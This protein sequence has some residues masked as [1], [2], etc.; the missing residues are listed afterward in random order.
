MFY[1]HGI[2]LVTHGYSVAPQVLCSL[3]ITA[4]QCLPECDATAIIFFC[5][6]QGPGKIEEIKF[7]KEEKDQWFKHRL[8]LV[9][10]FTA[11]MLPLLTTTI[12][13]AEIPSARAVTTSPQSPGMRVAEPQMDQTPSLK[14]GKVVYDPKDRHR[15]GTITRLFEDGKATVDWKNE[16]KIRDKKYNGNKLRVAT[17]VKDDYERPN[18]QGQAV[19]IVASTM[20]PHLVGKMGIV[21]RYST[22]SSSVQTEDGVTVKIKT[23]NLKLVGTATGRKVTVPASEFATE[24][25]FSDGFEE[26]MTA[27]MREQNVRL[28]SRISI[29]RFVQEGTAAIENFK[30]AAEEAEGNLTRARRR[31]NVD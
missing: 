7:G 6:P 8:R 13:I 12:D 17:V 20:H 3:A 24:F 22:D 2:K 15:V 19:Q 26:L 25:P 23:A 21:Q 27:H 18:K 29:A 10:F 28:A 14:V 30:R 5:P 1:A 9:A 31:K 11:R 4:G 16:Q